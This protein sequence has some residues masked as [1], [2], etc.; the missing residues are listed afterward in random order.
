MAKPTESTE[1]ESPIRGPEDFAATFGASHETLNRLATYERL[2][3]QWQSTINLVAPSTLDAIWHRHF[4]DSAQLLPLAS[5]AATWI[6]LGSGAGFPG[7]VIAILLAD[8][9]S[10]RQVKSTSC[11]TALPPPG[12]GRAMRP[13]LSSASAN[14]APGSIGRAKPLD[15]SGGGGRSRARE[16][17][18]PDAPN[19]L[20]SQVSSRLSG[21][22]KQTTL[23][24]GAS[25]SLLEGEA[26][27]PTTPRIA[28]I[29]SNARKCAFL[30]EVVRQTGI[31]ACV[32][33]DILSTR[34]EAAATQASLRG[35]DVVSAR[36]LAPLDRLFNLAASLSTPRTV[37]LFLKGRDAATELKAAE[38]MWDFNAELVPSRTDPD[39]RV[40]VIRHLQPKAKAKE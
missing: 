16:T 20:A 31:S 6:D 32:T 24:R 26:E 9:A 36:A 14:W 39:A 37:G 19:E 15:A 2:L 21:R 1:L 22:S 23:T 27:H 40:V 7:M 4:A 10:G 3:R 12:G 13:R 18:P 30:R 33:V 29:E 11:A 17:P 5:K 35:P 38:K 8:P 28:L 34:I 25:S